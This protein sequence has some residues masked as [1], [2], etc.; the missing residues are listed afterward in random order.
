M[1]VRGVVDQRVRD[2]TRRAAQLRAIVS[3]SMSL[4][5]KATGLLKEVDERIRADFEVVV[6]D[7]VLRFT[8]YA[9]GWRTIRPSAAPVPED[10]VCLTERSSFPIKIADGVETSCFRVAYELQDEVME[11]LWQ[12]WPALKV[13]G[14]LLVQIPALDSWGKACW[15]AEGRFQCPVGYLRKTLEVFGL[16]DKEPASPPRSVSGFSSAWV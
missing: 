13:E 7:L 5:E 10:I 8:T 9:I 3:I 12:P 15:Q 2:G 4:L 1:L 6:P 14:S 11:G 16:I